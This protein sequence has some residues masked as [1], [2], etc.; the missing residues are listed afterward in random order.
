MYLASVDEAPV[1]VGW[2]T[3]NVIVTA[4]EETS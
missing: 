4:N 2:R 3:T 1:F